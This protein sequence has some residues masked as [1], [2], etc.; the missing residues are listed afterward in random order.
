M[1]PENK[2]KWLIVKL[3]GYV[4]IPLVLLILPSDFFDDGPPLCLSVRFLGQ[5]C[6]GCGMTRAAMHFIHFD[7]GGAAFY[8]LGIFIVLPVLAFF[9]ARGF[10]MDLKKYRRLN[11][12]L[13]NGTDKITS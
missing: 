12:Y 5:E 11:E 8:N 2:K 9:W 4:L 3:T 6:P 13:K 10:W 1:S 7:F